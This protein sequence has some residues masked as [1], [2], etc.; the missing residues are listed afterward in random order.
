MSRENAIKYVERKLKKQK[1]KKNKAKAALHKQVLKYL[2]IK[3]EKAPNIKKKHKRL[4][5]KYDRLKQENR[6]LKAQRAK[7]QEA[8]EGKKMPVPESSQKS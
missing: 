8:L 3:K 6:A 7:L 5:G 2:K 1:R 4:S